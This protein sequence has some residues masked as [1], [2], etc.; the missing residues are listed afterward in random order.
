MLDVAQNTARLNSLI[1]RYYTTEFELETKTES[2]FDLAQQSSQHTIDKNNQTLSIMDKYDAL[3]EQLSGD[4]KSVTI[5][6]GIDP[7]NFSDKNNPSP[8]LSEFLTNFDK[9]FKPEKGAGDY[10]YGDHN[11]VGLTDPEILANPTLINEA[12]TNVSLKHPKPTEADYGAEPQQSAYT[13]TETQK[14]EKGKEVQVTVPDKE[15]YNK[16]HKE[17][18]DKKREAEQEWEDKCAGEWLTEEKEALKD[19]YYEAAKEI[20]DSEQDRRFEDANDIYKSNRTAAQNMYQGFKDEISGKEGALTKAESRDKERLELESQSELKAL[21][22][23]ESMLDQ[24]IQALQAE[25]TAIKTEIDSLKQ[26]RNSNVQSDF[27]LFG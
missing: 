23:Q 20:Y 8:A 13:K 4:Y 25:V 26:E 15:A 27:K 18:E 3:H 1:A 11:T 19:K 16:A 24:E 21:S 6:P 10:A 12:T 5:W 9:Q 14:D 22:M 7:V 2:K 17:W